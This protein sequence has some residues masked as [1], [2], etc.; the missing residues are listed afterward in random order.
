MANSQTN[1]KRE[2]IATT[3]NEKHLH[4]R[5]FVSNK[6]ESYILKKRCLNK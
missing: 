5:E 6:S 2:M 4:K 1:N 3:T